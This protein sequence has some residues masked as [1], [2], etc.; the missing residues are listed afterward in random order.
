M[1]G[2][3]LVLNWNGLQWHETHEMQTFR[4]LFF[5][6]TKAFSGNNVEMPPL[7]TENLLWTS[8]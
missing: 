6:Q 8:N 1:F 5:K 2:K 4:W 3:L 7:V